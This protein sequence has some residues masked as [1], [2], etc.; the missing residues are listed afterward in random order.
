VALPGKET[1]VGELIAEEILHERIADTMVLWEIPAQSPT[2][3]AFLAA[4]RRREASVQE[5]A[6]EERCTTLIPPSFEEFLAG[7]SRNRRYQ[8]R[9]A[10]AAV[11]RLGVTSRYPRAAER[12]W[13]PR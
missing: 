3:N 5:H 9:H 11:E 7:L 13:M 8:Y 12:R 1:L 4:M 10:A 6:C 2:A